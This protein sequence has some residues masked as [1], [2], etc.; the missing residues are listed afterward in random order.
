MFT[1]E[2]FLAGTVRKDKS[3]SLLLGKNLSVISIAY[4]QLRV[5]REKLNN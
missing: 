5:V 3:L 1:D 4:H 2:V